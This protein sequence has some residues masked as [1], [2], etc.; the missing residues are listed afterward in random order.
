MLGKKQ[1]QKLFLRKVGWKLG[2]SM[3]LKIL[4]KFIKG[5]QKITPLSEQF[6][7]NHPHI[8]VSVC[9]IGA[10]RPLERYGRTDERTQT[11]A[12]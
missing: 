1:I 6:S 9:I 12:H 10:G 7:N 5:N 2:R 11:H 4:T 3:I 8:M